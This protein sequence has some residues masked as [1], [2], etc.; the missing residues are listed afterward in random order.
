MNTILKIVLSA[1]AVMFLGWLLPGVS[2]D[3]SLFYAIIVAAVIGLL[4]A[5]IRPIFVFLTLPATLVTL[6]LFLLVI[7]AG[8]IMLADWALDGFAVTNFWWALLFSIL[9]SA[10][11]SVIDKM[12]NGDKKQLSTNQPRSI[13]IDKDGNRIE[14]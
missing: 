2:V 5:V 9:L 3:E 4:N 8:M 7:N 6:G 14:E 1:V 13:L 11:N 12:L 10:F